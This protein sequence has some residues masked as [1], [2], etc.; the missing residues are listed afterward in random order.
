M[1]AGGPLKEFSIRRDTS[2]QA[3]GS[4]RHRRPAASAATARACALVAVTMRLR[5]LKASA[6]RWFGR[7]VELQAEP[8]L[9]F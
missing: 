5:H 1:N 6:V 9:K 2:A 8:S 3:R 4:E 7:D